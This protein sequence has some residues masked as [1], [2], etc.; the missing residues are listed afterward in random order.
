M[1]TNHHNHRINMPSDI[2]QLLKDAQQFIRTHKIKLIIGTPCYGGVVHCSYFNSMLELATNFTRLGL[3]YEVMIIGN[4]SLITRARNGIVARFYADYEATH[5]MFI[6]A[7]ITFNWLSIIKLLL[8]EKDICG[9][10]Y[11]KKMINW[12]KVRHNL[13]T[14]PTMPDDML[15][16]KSLDY[17][18]NPIYFEEQGKLVCRVDKGLVKVKDIGTGFMLIKKSVFFTLMQRHPE[19]HYKN[20]VAGYD[21]NNINDYFYA[22]FDTAIDADSG[23]YLSEDYL[24]CKRWLAAGGELWLDLETNLNHTGVIDFK[25]CISQNI[26]TV[27]TLNHD[28]Q[29]MSKQQ[30]SHVNTTCPDAISTSSNSAAAAATISP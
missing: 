6:D 15:L 22:L 13:A 12:S 28:A 16:C 29:M 18:F 21:T 17:V 25:G 4:E 5:L 10:C 2:E 3:K 30:H 26:S 9:G 23:V 14:T 24:F 20:N 7:D 8:S 11:P 27:D 19:L 1:I